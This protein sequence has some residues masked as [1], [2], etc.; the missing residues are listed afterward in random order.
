MEKKKKLTDIMSG[1]RKVLSIRVA[2]VQGVRCLLRG[3]TEEIY[4][5]WVDIISIKFNENYTIMNREMV[6]GSPLLRPIWFPLDECID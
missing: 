3:Q 5:G 2:T 6:A 4:P 1:A